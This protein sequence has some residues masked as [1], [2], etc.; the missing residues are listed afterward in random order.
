MLLIL[1][2]NYHYYIPI[3]QYFHPNIRRE[4]TTDVSE[5]DEEVELLDLRAVFFAV[6]RMCAEECENGLCKASLRFSFSRLRSSSTVTGLR[7]GASGNLSNRSVAKESFHSG[8]F[9]IRFSFDVIRDIR[10]DRSSTFFSLLH[11]FRSLAVSFFKVNARRC[12][13]YSFLFLIIYF[14]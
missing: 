11:L 2:S 9:F 12:F 10:D 8:F 6:E 7:T 5:E 1:I 3:I 13:A 4:L 14:V